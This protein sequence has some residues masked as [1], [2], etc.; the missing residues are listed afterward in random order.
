MFVY[1]DPIVLDEIVKTPIPLASALGHERDVPPVQQVV[2]LGF[3]SPSQFALFVKEK[4]EQAYALAN[5]YL[6]EIQNA[7]KTYLKNVGHESHVIFSEIRETAG[8]LERNYSR[9]QYH[10]NIVVIITLAM[11]SM[12]AIVFYFR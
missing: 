2:S 6:T 11:A 8:I 10:R 7:Y 9:K 4:N 12:L 3:S 5:Q 1:S